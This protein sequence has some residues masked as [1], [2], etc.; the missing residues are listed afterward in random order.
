MDDV[1]RLSRAARQ[2]WA[3]GWYQRGVP[4][5]GGTG[6]RAWLP[7]WQHLHDAAGVAGQLWDSWLPQVVKTR[8]GDAAGGDAAG[9]VLVSLLAGV[10]DVGKASPAF[11]VQVDVLRDEM[12]RAGLPMAKAL[13][14]RG[15]LPHGLAGQVILER[16]LE[17]EHRWSLAE[18]RSLSSVVGAHHGIPALLTG[19]WVICGP[20]GR[21]GG[22][23]G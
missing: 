15:R 9:R 3:K 7:L 23:R 21:G 13:P 2:V 5:D 18:A 1:V 19:P 20:G 10:H 6:T 8:I 4:D 12:V 11:A 22:R 14:G 17:T 16:W